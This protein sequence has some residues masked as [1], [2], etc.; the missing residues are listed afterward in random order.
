MHTGQ[1]IDGVKCGRSDHIMAGLTRL[2]LSSTFSACSKDAFAQWYKEKRGV[3]TF[4]RDFTFLNFLQK[5]TCLDN[6]PKY[7][8]AQSVCGDGVL[9][10]SEE[11]DCG[12]D[13]ECKEDP[14]CDGS[15]CTYVDNAQCSA[16]DA[17]CDS[18]TCQIVSSDRAKVCRPARHFTCDTAE[19][20]DGKQSACPK[21]T[22]EAAG[23]QCSTKRLIDGG[24][25]GDRVAGD[26]YSPSAS[27]SQV[28]ASSDSDSTPKS[29]STSLFLLQPTTGLCFGGDCHSYASTCSQLHVV[30]SS[31]DQSPPHS[32][33]DAN[34]NTNSDDGTDIFESLMP[35]TQTQIEDLGISR[36][37]FCKQ[38]HCRYSTFTEST[39]IALD[40]LTSITSVSLSVLSS[41]AVSVLSSLSSSA[42]SSSFIP[43]GKDTVAHTPTGM[44]CGSQMQ[45]R[46][47]RYGI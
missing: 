41:A 22:Y 24:E 11:C 13:Q 44:P 4:F 20:C 36:D 28:G 26:P 19:V 37:E 5:D 29:P 23:L 15:T 3:G 27:S 16:M 43:V 6:T 18:A 33:D 40:S 25:P 46:A 1:Y 35:C 34:G 21:D 47:G 12:G 31:N 14:C 17:C 32:T 42:S 10:G 39:C 9:E 45:C 30:T 8:W 7:K 38:P 2:P